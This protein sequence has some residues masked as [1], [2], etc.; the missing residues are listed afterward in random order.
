MAPPTKAYGLDYSARELSPQEI[1]AF[2]RANPGT[3]ISFLIRY[4]G[5]P[6]NRKCISAYP[7]ALRAHEKSGRRVLLVHQV[8]Y[9]DFLGGYGAGAA[10]AHLSIAD[11][12]RQGWQHDTPIFAAYD[13]FL[14]G[15]P[16]NGITP[17]TL[18][19]VQDYVRGFRSVLGDL[20]GL[21]GFYDVMGPAVR[22]QW[23][24][25]FW[26]CGAESALVPGVQFYQW[27]NGRVSP[28]GMECDLNKS[29][30]DISSFGGDD[31]PLN[32]DTDQ[33]AFNTMMTRWWIFHARTKGGRAT[34]EDGPTAPEQLSSITAAVAELKAEVAQLKASGIP[35]DAKVDWHEGAKVINDDAD[36]RERDGDSSTGHTS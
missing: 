15:N 21:Y 28:G 23:T 8:A 24:K 16:A 3:P 5:Y 4:I 1:D 17:M 29:Y 20:A 36:A 2:N 32:A 26:Q 6:G 10:H 31:M 13:R 12:E 25:W 22:G 33:D 18:A 30:V 14:A 19:Q 9:N 11:A 34:W 27:N 35:V 7:G